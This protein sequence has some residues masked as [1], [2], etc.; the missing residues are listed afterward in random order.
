MPESAALHILD[1][2]KLD[3]RINRHAY[4][5]ILGKDNIQEDYSR[6]SVDQSSNSILKGD[7]IR[8]FIR[9]MSE[10]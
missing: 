5:K 3:D 8:T 1:D 2:F 6:I 7:D 10:N 4:K 9:A